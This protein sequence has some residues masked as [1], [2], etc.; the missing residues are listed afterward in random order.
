MSGPGQTVSLDKGAGVV[1]YTRQYNIAPF[2]WRAY[3][4]QKERFCVVLIT[5]PEYLRS[6]RLLSFVLN[7]F[8]EPRFIAAPGLS[9]AVRQIGDLG[10]ERDQ[11]RAQVALFDLSEGQRFAGIH[12][13]LIPARTNTPATWLERHQQLRAILPNWLLQRPNSQVWDKNF[14]HTLWLASNIAEVPRVL[15]TNAHMIMLTEPVDIKTFTTDRLG[16]AN[17][18][19]SSDVIF[20]VSSTLSQ[21]V[22]LMTLPKD[23]MAL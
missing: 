3:P 18:T 4:H 2:A 21:D 10:S 22:Q 7:A 14:S 9:D 11:L 20:A 12:P 5:S 8:L 17:A 1:T 13:S 15:L 16:A 19:V 6:S 23:Q